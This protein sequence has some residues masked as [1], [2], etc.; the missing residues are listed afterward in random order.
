MNIQIIAVT[1]V[2]AATLISGCSGSGTDM[3]GMNT[4]GQPAQVSGKVADGYLVSAVVFL[5]R[6]G[7]YQLDAGEPTTTTDASGAYTL[8]VVAAD[9]GKYPIIALAIKGQTVDKDTNQTVANSYLLSMPATAV[10]GTVSSNFISPMSTLIREKMTVNSGISMPDAMAQLRN[11]MNLSAGTD[12]M[13]DY[14]AASQSG[15]NA[16]DYQIMH[17]TARQMAGLME[18]QASLVMNNGSGANLNRYR[19]MMATIN[20]NM[21]GVAANVMNGSGMNSTFMTNMMSQLQSQLGAMPVGGTFMN[22]SGMF[23]NMTSHSSFWSN[24]GTPMTPMSGGMMK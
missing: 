10:S 12:M 14:I 11:Q 5:D 24:T 18:G 8:N 4:Q 17:A 13:A 16:V 23:R 22:Y 6:N 7:N 3:N 21:S 1:I 19:S 2:A 9:I 15:P 20:S